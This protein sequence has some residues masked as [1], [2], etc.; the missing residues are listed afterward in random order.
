[1]KGLTRQDADEYNDLAAAPPQKKMDSRNGMAAFV[2]RI[3]G[4]QSA[5]HALAPEGTEPPFL[6]AQIMVMVIFI[7]LTAFAVK[8][9]HPAPAHA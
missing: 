2:P 5:L 4:S 1:M 8:K 7:V 3:D 6:G 9:F